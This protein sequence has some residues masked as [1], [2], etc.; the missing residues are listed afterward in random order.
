VPLFFGW[1]PL[2]C[3]GSVTTC[4]L[5]PSGTLK[6]ETESANSC[7]D[8]LGS[9]LWRDRVSTITNDRGATQQLPL[10]WGRWP[11]DRQLRSMLL[12]FTPGFILR[13]FVIR[14]AVFVI[15]ES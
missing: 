11:F 3:H 14:T 1:G 12:E 5:E 10:G 15:L 2:D 9:L 13:E 6:F 4:G 7:V 8:L